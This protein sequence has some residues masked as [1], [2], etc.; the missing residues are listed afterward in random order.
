MRIV[1]MGTPQFAV[2]SLEALAGVHEIVGVVTATDKPAGRGQKLWQ[3]PVKEAAVKLGIPVLQPEKLRDEL[4][5]D[6]LRGLHADLFV[7]VAF[8]MLPEQVWAMPPMGTINL[9]A[10]LL[11]QY[12]GAAPINHAIIN[13]E[14]RTGLTTFF[15]EKE[16][17]TG[18]V[19]ARTEVSIGPDETAG[20]LHDKMM[21]SG[22]G[23]L[24][25]TVQK[26]EL[27]RIEPVDQ[28]ELLANE[29]LNPAPKIFKEHCRIH[30]NRPAAQ[31]HNHIRG[32][33]P[34]P[35]AFAEAK[36]DDV[37]VSYKITGSQLSGLKTESTPGT[38]QIRDGKLMCATTDEW[39]EITAI[40]APGKRNLPSAE[41]LNGWR[42]PE[43][44]VFLP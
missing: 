25:D 7:V 42:M 8:R 2:P 36:A 12:R 31:V 19:I 16:I 27:G 6:T 35:G 20:E 32:L 38:V 30:W 40:Q 3:S 44:F 18:K 1:Y 43:G 11:P 21:L 22:A 17:D 26:I 4:F 13:G 15:I 14:T 39:L 23:L 37:A 24:V 10:S 28:V 33:S 5:L 41:F 9:H 29:A 34:F